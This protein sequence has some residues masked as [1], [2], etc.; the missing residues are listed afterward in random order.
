MTNKVWLPDLIAHI[1][2]HDSDA[3]WYVARSYMIGMNFVP[4][5]TEVAYRL[6]K[7]SKH[8]DAIWICSLMERVG[9][10]NHFL[11]EV[12]EN[13]D[14]IHCF[15]HLQKHGPYRDYR[16]DGNKYSL[17]LC[18][19][20]NAFAHYA[21]VA[22]MGDPEGMFQ[23]VIR[24]SA[25]RVKWLKKAAKLGHANSAIEL[26]KLIEIDDPGFACTVEGI[27]FVSRIAFV[28]SG[29]YGLDHWC[30]KM[31][32]YASQHVDFIGPVFYEIGQTFILAERHSFD[33][34]CSQF[35]DSNHSKRVDQIRRNC[36]ELYQ[37]N[38]VQTRLAVDMWTL[39]AYRFNR[40][41]GKI[42][43]NV[44]VRRIVAKM[45]WTS[46]K[47]GLYDSGFPV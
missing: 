16:L 1:L 9:V 35:H 22:E 6:A 36:I 15:R 7:M 29:L 21:A 37:A 30:D 11:D 14:R 28:C 33:M 25:D 19:C 26:G 34:Q 31:T 18:F 13:D 44:D 40:A 17:A 27:Q 5:N 20:T 46:R 8:P 47:E 12:H 39:V 23:L 4:V 2:D 41:I 42:A 10:S 24:K 32:K 3:L 43:L 38:N 45:I